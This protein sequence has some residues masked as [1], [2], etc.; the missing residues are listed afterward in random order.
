MLLRLEVIKTTTG[1]PLYKLVYEQLGIVM[2]HEEFQ[3]L[4]KEV[5]TEYMVLMNR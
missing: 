3:E 2:N 1:F 4:A 5:L